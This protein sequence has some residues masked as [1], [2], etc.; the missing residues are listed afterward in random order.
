MQEP[1][2]T[3]INARLPCGQDV[4]VR[5]VWIESIVGEDCRMQKCP[6]CRQRIM[7]KEDEKDLERGKL[8]DQ[9]TQYRDELDSWLKL[10]SLQPMSRHQLFNSATLMNALNIAVSRVSICLKP[11]LLGR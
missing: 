6:Y 9:D 7:Q 3:T 11:Y 2:D 8:F 5:K 10:E 1:G 4:H